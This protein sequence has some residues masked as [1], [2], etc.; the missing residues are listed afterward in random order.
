MVKGM[1]T[2]LQ[3]VVEGAATLL[4][5]VVLKGKCLPLIYEAGIFIF[6]LSSESEA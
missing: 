5:T 6:T 2:F 1:T 3:S 4:L